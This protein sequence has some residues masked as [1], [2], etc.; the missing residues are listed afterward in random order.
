MGSKIDFCPYFLDRK[1]TIMVSM[2]SMN[3]SLFLASFFRN[4]GS[5]APKWSE[6]D[7]DAICAMWGE[8]CESHKEESPF[9]D[10][11]KGRAVRVEIGKIVREFSQV[12]GV[13]IW[14]EDVWDSL[15]ED[16]Y[17]ALVEAVVLNKIV[18][19]SIK[20]ALEKTVRTK[21]VGGKKAPSDR[22]KSAY[23][24]C[25]NHYRPI[26]KAE[27]P[28]VT[29]Q[30]LTK[31]L[32]E[33]W[34]LVQVSEEYKE[35]YEG[36]LESARVDKERY[37]ALHPKPPKAAKA[38]KAPSSPKKPKGKPRGKSAWS[39]FCQYKRESVKAELP[40]GSTN[41]D[42]MAKLGEMW[43]ST[44]YTEEKTRAV[45]ESMEDKE[46]VSIL[47]A[48]AE[49]KAASQ[50]QFTQILIEEESDDEETNVEEETNVDDETNVDE[51]TIVEETQKV[52]VKTEPEVVKTSV[53]KK[54]KASTPKK[55]PGVTKKTPGAPKKSV[56][57]KTVV[58]DDA[59]QSV[60]AKL[61]ILLGGYDT[62]DEVVDE[63]VDE[64]LFA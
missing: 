47:N 15:S 57:K 64:S 43:S 11:P 44:D 45:R 62:E 8:W 56:A 4:T 21:T 24:Y 59:V 32:G 10:S 28:N 19:A 6:D 27:N 61:D 48:E 41:K 33:K 30:Q 22:N 46:R 7:I 14:A 63:V 40:E 60:Q 39:F 16:R 38:A 42:V 55:T 25:C 12:W 58:E 36:F 51:E 49:A 31:L 18:Q 13:T 50:T 2:T 34:K 37:E 1:G 54:T 3:I 9:T 26:L 17:A 5:L 52:V 53:V 29:P 35:V 20:A 23:L